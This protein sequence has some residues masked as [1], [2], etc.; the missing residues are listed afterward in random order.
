MTLQQMLKWYDEE[1]GVVGIY[2]ATNSTLERRKWLQDTLTQQDIQVFFIESICEDEALVAANIKDVKLSSPDY[3]LMDPEKAV[4]DFQARIAQYTSQYQTIVEQDYSYIKLINVGSQVIV[5]MVKGY[6][7]SRIV[8]YLMNLHIR[9]RKI[10]MSRHGESMFNLKGLLGGDADLSP[11]GRLY[12]EMLPGIVKEK[13][14][15][16]ELVVWTSTLK[17]TIQTSEHLPYLKQHRKALDELDAGVCDGLTYEQVEEKYPE[18]FARR[19]DDKFNYRY[20]GGESYRDVVHRLEPIIMDLERQEDIL[21]VGHQAIIRCL[22]GYFMNYN[23]EDLPYIK[24]P[25]HTLIE[26]TPKAYYCEEKF[27]KADIPAVDTHRP[28]PTER[29]PPIN[30]QAVPG[31]GGEVPSPLLP[32]SSTISS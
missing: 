4:S 25:L 24:I 8:Y 32:P 2:D 14:G 16:K 28:K 6:L 17:R 19:D 1:D 12:A 15:G 10:Y 3:K 20:R 18:D 22:Y 13:L 31:S 30:T 26:L 9:G 11:R 23:Q 21:I 5:N 29:R 7:E 27:Y